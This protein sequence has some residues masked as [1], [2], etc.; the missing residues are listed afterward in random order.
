MTENENINRRELINSSA[1]AGLA[2]AFGFLG[3]NNSAK[4]QTQQSAKAQTQ[5]S[6]KAITIDAP[7]KK[8]FVEQKISSQKY[9][10]ID[11]QNLIE[12]IKGKTSQKFYSDNYVADNS[13][14][15]IPAIDTD[16][17]FK[18]SEGIKFHPNKIEDLLDQAA[19]LL[20]RGLR[21]R[22]EWD[23]L[24]VRLFY[25]E[26][27]INQ[28]IELDKIHQEE[29]RK[30][31][32]DQLLNEK[33]SDLNI[34]KLNKETFQQ[35]SEM[36]SDMFAKLWS[37]DAING[38]VNN[39]A[40]LALINSGG[41]TATDPSG[42]QAGKI[43]LDTTGFA[44][45]YNMAVQRVYNF[46]QNQG[47]L[48]SY[49][50]SKLKE[51]LLKKQVD[52]EEIDRDFRLMR[53]DV[54]RKYEYIKLAAFKSEDGVLNLKK[55][56]DPLKAR[57][58]NDFNEARSR[59]EAASIGLRILFGYQNSLPDFKGQIDYFDRCILWNREAVNWLIRT[60]QMD[61]SFVTTVS[62]KRLLESKESN[63]LENSIKNGQV[64]FSIDE[65]SFFKDYSN[66]RLKGTSI[67]I[68][69]SEKRKAKKNVGVL[70]YEGIVQ[71]EITI[72]SNTYYRYGD[73]S[74]KDFNQSYIPVVK[75]NRIASRSFV[76]QPD[77][78]GT[79][80]FNNLSPIGKWNL[81]FPQ[82]ANDTFLERFNINDIQL[83]LFITARRR[84]R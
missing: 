78:V 34:E 41:W 56:M 20:D 16:I 58:R 69:L 76:R 11:F 55:R 37:Q 80:L 6:A 73:G 7:I 12:E 62:L 50:Q 28:F 75:L 61:Q 46:V 44:E 17:D 19:N 51:R 42:K 29:I 22:T 10:Q 65:D 53:T 59:L 13:I 21:D 74:T 38:Q 27:E 43:A 49:D 14:N 45:H 77:I 82:M 60:S 35:I 57:F 67:F 81:F 47:F 66:V 1:L 9:K 8:P 63:T 4:G 15:L 39:R 48:N 3:V 18:I 71:C 79:S 2:L 5:Q 23:D 64:T 26:I 24:S 52:W 68:Q 72:P 40:T 70:D 36:F 32:Y 83:D 33:L 25:L 31:Y 30:G 84:G 54:D